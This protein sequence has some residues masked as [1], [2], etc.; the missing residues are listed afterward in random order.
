MKK[1]RKENRVWSQAD[2]ALLTDII[3]SGR[4]IK[5]D[6]LQIFFPGKAISQIRSKVALIRSKHMGTLDFMREF[7]LIEKA[8]THT[9][10]HRYI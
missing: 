3:L 2:I 7:N 8:N 6:E 5:L 9:R 10:A 4:N 1:V